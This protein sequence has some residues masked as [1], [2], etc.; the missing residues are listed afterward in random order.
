[1]S[2]GTGRRS[3][4]LPF[5]AALAVLAARLPVL[6][7]HQDSHYPFELFS[8]NVA[9][10][11]LD[12]L[13][14]ELSRLTIIPHIRGGPL[15]GLMG[16]PLFALFGESLVVL[17]LVPLIWHAITMALA[18]A[19][20][21]RYGGRSAAWAG[22]GL[23]VCAPP[24]LAKLSVLGLASHLES[25]LPA[26][27]A[28]LAWTPIVQARRTDRTAWIR[29]GL[30]VGFSSFFHLQALL[31][32][33]ILLALLLLRCPRRLGSGSLPLL[34]GLLLAAA[35]QLLFEGHDLSLGLSV[36][37]KAPH[38]SVANTTPGPIGEVALFERP[39]KALLMGSQGM[40]PMLEYSAEPAWA[41]VALSHL[42]W[43]ALLLAAAR[44]AWRSR[45]SLVDLVRRPFAA[46]SAV[47][48]LGTVLVVHSLVVGV[49]FVSGGLQANLWFVGTGMASRRLIPMLMSLL[50]LAALGCSRRNPSSSRDENVRRVLLGV[51]LVC[52]AIGSVQAGSWNRAARVPHR[53][54]YY[55]WFVPQ[56]DHH[57]DGDPKQ[58]VELVRRVDRG[59][60]RF[61]SLRYPLRCFDLSSQEPLLLQLAR[62]RAALPAT[63][64]PL[65]ALTSLGR[66]WGRDDRL[67]Q[68]LA[69][70]E[71]LSSLTDL[72]R[73]AFL[74][75]VGL[76]LAPKWT[77]ASASDTPGTIHP[78]LP[79]L[80][81][82]LPADTL[83][84]I[85]EGLGFSRGQ[86]HDPYN[87]YMARELDELSQL[88]APLRSDL[89]R[90][91][92]WGYRQ[93]YASP[94]GEVPDGLSVLSH[95]AP[96]D[97]PDFLEALLG[98]SLPDE[99]EP[100]GL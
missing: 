86:V 25:Y 8:G 48:D 18:V 59:D 50:L 23:A 73:S 55:E 43:I 16:A 91:F 52:G 31:P 27:L 51:L 95:I 79:Y 57:A 96:A 49:L 62:A 99:A 33:L 53:G 72:E 4:P 54:E 15:F 71:L 30:A 12:G 77:R 32:C 44:G 97:Q 29:L 41:R 92:G 85:F 10:A 24:L 68:M 88:T 93:R 69:N 42:W 45:Q 26:L 11:L 21:G 2:I 63:I 81:Q 75:G 6:L 38:Q 67:P 46:D 70:E 20:L 37:G 65:F 94:P 60:P 1:M 13:N 82:Q 84:A 19:L 100:L 36:M 34:C 17:K 47:P 64:A 3:L 80:G 76:G 89:L 39:A 74:H 7:A 90:G 35:P 87:H 14:L 40:A 78:V 83:P 9:A 58:L 5:L 61:A 66:A 56:L 28:L 98:Q 22:L